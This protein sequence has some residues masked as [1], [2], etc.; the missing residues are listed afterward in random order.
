MARIKGSAATKIR[1][2]GMKKGWL[3]I[4]PPEHAG[5]FARF[6]ISQA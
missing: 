6:S 3:I 1:M 4:T 5:Y 2:A